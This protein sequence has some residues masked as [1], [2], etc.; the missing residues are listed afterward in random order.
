MQYDKAK[1]QFIQAWG[2]LGSA[3][4]INKAMGQ[5][6]ALLLI[7]EEAL[8]TEDIMEEL[9]ISRGNANMNLRSLMDWG[10]VQKVLKPGERKEYFTTGKDILEL[11]RQVSRE[12]RRREIEPVMRVLNEVQEVEGN[13]PQVEH[14][15]KV[16]GDL[17]G[18][19]KQ[20][21]GA[22]DKFIRSDKNWFF[23]VL[24]KL[25]R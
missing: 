22:L 10:I 20:V 13:T 8:T 25:M 7:T 15:K 2:T 17:S 23:Q 9:K 5:I 18:F 12:R 6:H 14:F 3:W 11:A 1:D 16:T 24:M 21:D 4:G 19:T